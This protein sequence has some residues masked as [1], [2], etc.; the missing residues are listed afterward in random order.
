MKP[1]AD[2]LYWASPPMKPL[3]VGLW[4]HCWRDI[5]VG[6]V[7][8]SEYCCRDSTVRAE[9]LRRLPP[10]VCQIGLEIMVFRILAFLLNNPNLVYT[11]CELWLS[12]FSL[13]M[14]HTNYRK[15]SFLLD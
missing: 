9:E 5:M 8:L 3:K 7:Y 10:S 1:T 12:Y 2:L 4:E 14:E 15:L 11:S 6:K 13:V